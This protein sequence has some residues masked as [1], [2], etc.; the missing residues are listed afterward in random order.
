MTYSP[1]RGFKSNASKAVLSDDKYLSAAELIKS[2]VKTC[3]KR[4]PRSFTKNK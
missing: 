3:I 4:T 1:S 2:L